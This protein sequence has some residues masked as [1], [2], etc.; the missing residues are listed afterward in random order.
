MKKV[1]LIIV[2]ALILLVVGLIVIKNYDQILP[3]DYSVYPDEAYV[4]SVDD[5][6]VRSKIKN[7]CGCSGGGSDITV[8][9]NY[10][11]RVVQRLLSEV[12]CPAV[13]SNHWTCKAS[14]KCENSQ[15]RLVK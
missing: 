7:R 2:I 12:G 8:N 13:M 5:D 4:C 11:E 9:K 14:P 1:L 15:C 6:C 10:H 3:V